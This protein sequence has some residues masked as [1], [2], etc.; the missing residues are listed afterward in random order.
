MYVGSG[1]G[2][3]DLFFSFHKAF[4]VCDTKVEYN[5]K[6]I[7]WCLGKVGQ[8]SKAR[9]PHPSLSDLRFDIIKRRS[10]SR[11]DNFNQ[12]LSFFTPS[13]V[14]TLWNFCYFGFFF[15]RLL[16]PFSTPALRGPGH[17]LH[18][19]WQ[20]KEEADH[21]KADVMHSHWTHTGDYLYPFRFWTASWQLN[22][23]L[24]WLIKI[25]PS[26]KQTKSPAWNSCSVTN[27]SSK[28]VL[29]LKQWLKRHV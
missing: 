18:L 22:G 29:G 3:C 9:F 23:Y 14:F 10:W 28:T 21:S 17:V 25:S 7:L 6:E 2:K 16:K 4:I 19:Y 8:K 5:S 13:P 20:V 11:L 1:Y 24:R 26:N 12:L 27:S 15:L